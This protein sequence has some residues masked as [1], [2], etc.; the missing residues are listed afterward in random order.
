[1]NPDYVAY[2]AVIGIGKSISSS[3]LPNA[4]VI[5]DSNDRPA[6][7]VQLAALRMRVTHLLGAAERATPA[8]SQPAT[9]SR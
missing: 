9:A 3:A 6:L 4:P 5:D 1:M 7:R 2:L 8:H